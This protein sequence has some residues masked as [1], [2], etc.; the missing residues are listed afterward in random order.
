MKIH[1]SK[2]SIVEADRVKLND[3][4]LAYVDTADSKQV[5]S[6]VKEPVFSGAYGES[7]LRAYAEFDS[8]NA[9]LFDGSGEIMRNLTLKR[10]GNRYVYEPQNMVEFTPLSFSYSALVKK[11]MAFKNNAQYNLN[12]AVYEEGADLAFSKKLIAVFGDAPRR[13]VCPANIS[14]NNQDMT[15]ESLINA[16]FAGKDFIFIQ[17]ADGVHVKQGKS[18]SVLDVN[19]LMDMNVNVWLSVESF[20]G[21]METKVNNVYTLASPRLYSASQYS[22]PNYKYH[23]NTNN[24]HPSYPKSKYIYSSPFVDGCAALVMEKTNGGYVIITHKSFFDNL[25][26]NVRLLYELMMQ[27]FLKGYYRTK[28]YRSWI[29]DQPVDYVAYKNS[30]YNLRHAAINLNEMLTNTNYDIGNEYTL[31][32][33]K[34]SNPNIVFTNM[35]PKKDLFFYKIN[36]QPDPVKNE[37][38]ISLYT[39]KHSVIHYR[40]EVIKKIESGLSISTEVADTGMYVTVHPC[41]STKHRICTLHDQRFRMEDPRLTYILCC[42]PGVPDIEN[43]FEL[44]PNDEYSIFNGFKLAT[45]KV[46]T[47]EEAKVHDIRIEGGG[48]PL[49]SEPDYNM[50]D[51]GHINGRPYRIG[52]T[53]I[54]R[55]PAK[56]KEH[57]DKIM[58]AIE[59]HASSGDYPVIIFE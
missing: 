25:H 17:S 24:E 50:I 29:T 37:G 19:A 34:T 42:K 54:I 56:L 7:L 33:V 23:F 16:S 47:T 31:L 46:I 5:I 9:Y 43:A 58:V 40:Q 44:I 28:Q 53:M 27:T 4:P 36:V 59:K 14:V 15:P 20:N 30:K 32:E 21:V 13:G 3:I 38:D 8:P 12:V 11:N 1:L 10:L 6:V 48:L 55:L 57:N 49:D 39:S 22:I 18:T 35:S 45:I 51:I 26:E 41:K 2:H 52:S